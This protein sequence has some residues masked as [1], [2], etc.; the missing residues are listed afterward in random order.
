MDGT[1]CYLPQQCA[2]MVTLTSTS[3]EPRWATKELFVICVDI[4]MFQVTVLCAKKGNLARI[5]DG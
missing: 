2:M 4:D 3:P 5:K 1:L